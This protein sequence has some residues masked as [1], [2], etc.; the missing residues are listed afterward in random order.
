MTFM[1]SVTSLNMQE[2]TYFKSQSL[3][4]KAGNKIMFLV[5][6]VMKKHDISYWHED[7]IL[8]VQ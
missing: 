1:C 2:L 7:S 8:F 4:V 3:H 6:Y 5:S